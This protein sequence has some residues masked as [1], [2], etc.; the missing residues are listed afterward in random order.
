[1]K[2]IQ[3]FLGVAFVCAGLCFLF[4]AARANTALLRKRRAQGR[5]IFSLTGTLESVQT[6]E[7]FSFALYL[8][9]AIFSIQFGIS[10]GK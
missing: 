5:S 3:Q 9:L 10:F 6:K 7:F 1:V 8:V 2:S 4:L